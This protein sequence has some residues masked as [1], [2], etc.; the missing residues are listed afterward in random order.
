MGQSSDGMIATSIIIKVEVKATEER[1][2][3]GEGDPLA[4][5]RRNRKLYV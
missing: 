1:K 5:L 3:K 4:F 2:R